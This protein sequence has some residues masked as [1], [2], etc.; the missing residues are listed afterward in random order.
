MPR[1]LC[2]E[3]APLTSRIVVTRAARPVVVW[4]LVGVGLALALVVAFFLILYA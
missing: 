4:L 1:R 3:L 2:W